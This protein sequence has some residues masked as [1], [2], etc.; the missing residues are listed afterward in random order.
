MSRPATAIAATLACALLIVGCTDTSIS[1]TEPSRSATAPVRSV[2]IVETI[3]QASTLAVP[4]PTPPLT[5]IIT[6]TAHGFTFSHPTNWTLLIPNEHSPME[7]GPLVYLSTD[8]LQSSCFGLPGAS[9]QLPDAHGY[10]CSWPL[11]SLQPGSILITIY[12]TR[13]LAPLSS[14]GSASIQ[15]NGQAAV[16]VTTS[17]GLCRAIGG[18][19][20]I[21]VLIPISQPTPLSNLGVEAC[22]REPDLLAAE[23]Q[24]RTFLSSLTVE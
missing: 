6:E 19:E 4:T 23:A 24:V 12:T 11:T 17:P 8:D 9:P 21:D 5:Q 16:V 7:G 18:D 1:S 10:A 20:S 3:P 13:L 15:I 14:A 2:A 22:L